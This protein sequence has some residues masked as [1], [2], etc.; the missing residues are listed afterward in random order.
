[1]NYVTSFYTDNKTIIL[2]VFILVLLRGLLVPDFRY[3]LVSAIIIQ[4]IFP[5]ALSAVFLMKGVGNQEYMAKIVI[6]IL[7]MVLSEIISLIVYNFMAG[8]EGLKDQVS[9]ALFIGSFVGQIAVFFLALG[10][11]II[12]RKL[13]G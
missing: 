5:L 12:V 4:I 1:M 13:I 3:G 2:Y 11:V 10:L 9:I 6:C 7:G 8:P